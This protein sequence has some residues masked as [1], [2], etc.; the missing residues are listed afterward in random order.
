MRFSVDTTK[1]YLSSESAPYKTE[2]FIKRTLNL[3]DIDFFLSKISETVWKNLQSVF[4]SVSDAQA[5]C[6]LVRTTGGHV[7]YFRFGAQCA[8]SGLDSKD[9]V[10]YKYEDGEGEM[11]RN[12][13]RLAAFI[14][15]HPVFGIKVEASVDA[16]MSGDFKKLYILSNADQVN[17]P[18]LNPKQ[19]EIVF[20]EDKNVVVQGVAGS[21]KTNICLNKIVYAACRE[22]AGKV[23]YTTFSRGLLLDV[24]AKIDILKQNMLNFVAEYKDGNLIFLDKNYKKAVEN[25]LGIFLTEEEVPSIIAKA[26]A[27]A[28]FLDNRVDYCLLEDLYSRYIASEYGFADETYFIRTY[29][30]NIKNHQLMGKLEKIAYLSKEVIYKEIYGMINGCYDYLKP[31]PMLALARYIELRKDSF[32]KKECEIIYSIALDYSKHIAEKGLIDNNVIS[33]AL[34][35]RAEIIESYSLAV[36]DEAQDM[37]EVNLALFKR[38]ALKLFAVGDALQM[39]NP[40]YF[41]FAYLKRLLFEK[42]IVAVAELVNNYRNTKKIA[43]IVEKLGALNIARF[44]THSFVLKG[45]S[46]DEGAETAAV[47]VLGKGFIEALS[48]R[49]LDGYTV[50][51]PNIKE[52]EALRKIL[53]RQEIL[54]V[55]EIKGLER[56]AVIIYNVLSANFDKW[57]RFE[58]LLINRKKADENSVYR[59]YFN[60]FYV[61]VSRAKHYLY[62]A[63]ERNVAMFDD[64][65]TEHFAKRDIAEALETLSN[66]VR[67]ADDDVE[68]TLER[69]R[70]FTALDQYDNARHAANK[71]SDDM[72]RMRELTKIDIYERFIRH[73]KY[74]EAGIQYWQNNMP[75][76]AKEQFALSKD[77]I[78]SELVDACQSEEGKGLD[79]EILRY[80]PEVGGNPVA[81][82]LIIQTVKT[83][84]ASLSERQKS[85]Q[86]KFRR[87]KEKKHG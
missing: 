43:E 44:G 16:I 73:G 53:K 64:L 69:I 40:S 57:K 18:H 78:L 19:K 55:S 87:I 47:A 82:N 2:R 34:L 74:R 68:E 49:K 13:Q 67:A 37:T 56:E 61:A 24:K 22:Y 42:D 72:V 71:L 54:T 4:F 1:T 20:T 27:V 79:I 25:K 39:I 3:A 11:R 86:G 62:V 26:E 10:F 8:K 85:L 59:Y 58:R 70:R 50:V 31:Q 84:L 9:I 14:K 12:D 83:D 32:S 81:A 60:L 30:R 48:E 38:I 75:K 65:F 17:F 29:T 45:E 77:N 23:L 46:V 80:L 41:S 15:A 33:R 35:A 36:I 63:E 21:G 5:G 66:A 28:R 52:K 76:E 51:V 7:V 6:F